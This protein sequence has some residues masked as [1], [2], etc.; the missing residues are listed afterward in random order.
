MFTQKFVALLLF[1]LCCYNLLM[2]SDANW[3]ET[4]D[5]GN[6]VPVESGLHI[7]YEATRPISFLSLI[8]KGLWFVPTLILS[9]L[10]LVSE[11]KVSELSSSFITYGIETLRRFLS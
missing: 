10:G 6:V 5:T 8:W 11:H 7:R 1:T 9:K 2:I 3:S 4:Y